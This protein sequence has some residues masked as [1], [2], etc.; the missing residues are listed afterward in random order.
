LLLLNIIV[1]L[2]KTM[3]LKFNSKKY[4]FDSNLVY[5]LLSAHVD[6]NIVYFENTHRNRLI[7][8][9]IYMEV[10]SSKLLFND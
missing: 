6:I 4:N 2:M 10:K 7:Y 8:I 5:Y 1:N 9:L 3:E